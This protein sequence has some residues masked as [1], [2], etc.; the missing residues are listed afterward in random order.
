L[1]VIA[2]KFI[3]KKRKKEN[4]EYTS[5]YFFIKIIL[6]GLVPRDILEKYICAYTGKAS[7]HLQHS[8]NDYVRVYQG[9]FLKKAWQH[10]TGLRYKRMRLMALYSLLTLHKYI[11]AD[12][13]SD[14][15]INVFI[16]KMRVYEYIYTYTHT[17]THTYTQNC[18]R[19]P[20]R[21]TW[22]L[23]IADHVAPG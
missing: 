21:A 4:I 3:Y 20:A 8:L 2:R 5:F 14:A 12:T 6:V 15:R 13:H 18:A 19:I 1:E 23:L 7:R 9:T 11:S 22:P 10:N 16:Y 17:H